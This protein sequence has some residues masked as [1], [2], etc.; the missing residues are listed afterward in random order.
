MEEHRGN[1]V[2]TGWMIK[3]GCFQDELLDG[4]CSS[5]VVL[6]FGEESYAT[7]STI[8]IVLWTTSYLSGRLREIG[9][10]F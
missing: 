1:S 6:S 9:G 3:L 5:K 4:A 8:N 7:D 10:D 2:E